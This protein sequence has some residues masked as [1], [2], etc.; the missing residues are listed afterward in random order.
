MDNQ[1]ATEIS[2]Q[3]SSHGDGA[4]FSPDGQMIILT[5]VTFVLL[6]A[7]LYKFAWKPIFAALDERERAIR[8]S[9][10]DAQRITKELQEIESARQKAI[11]EAQEKSKEILEQSRKGAIEQAKM[12][13]D[14]A[15]ED[16]EIILENGRREIK[17]DIETAKAELREESARI[18]V[19]LAEKLLEQNLDDEKNRKLVREFIKDL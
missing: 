19:A 8:K 1:S 2:V 13:H 9:V 6:L 12:I 7:I 10:D 15:R 5:W 11:H 17:D 14:K 16:A 4:L 18:A 3:P